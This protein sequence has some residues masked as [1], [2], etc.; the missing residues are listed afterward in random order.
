MFILLDISITCTYDSDFFSQLV[1]QI[2]RSH[3]IA[4]CMRFSSIRLCE[5]EVWLQHDIRKGTLNMYMPQ[6]FNIV[7]SDNHAAML[8]Q[9]WRS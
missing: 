3:S 9:F 4:N 2:S 5:K 6:V 7:H 1:V 8:V